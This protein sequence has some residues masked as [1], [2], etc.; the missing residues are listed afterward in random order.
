[1]PD[2]AQFVQSNFAVNVCPARQASNIMV[3]WM[4]YFSLHER[5]IRFIEVRTDPK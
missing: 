3:G 4:A 1:M 5:I 2:L